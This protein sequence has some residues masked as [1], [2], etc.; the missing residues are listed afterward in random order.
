I[1]RGLDLIHDFPLLKVGRLPSDLMM[2]LRHAVN[3]YL[4][5]TLDSFYRR[6]VFDLG[7]DFL[8]RT[9]SAVRGLPNITPNG[10]V[11][12]K[13]QNY[14]AYNM[15]HSTVAEIFTELGL[16]AHVVSAHAPINLRLVDGRANPRF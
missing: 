15:V 14:L 11:L 1:A 5:V 13:K 7:D 6:E 9:A 16:S 8:T 12:A 10:L 2:R 4:Y 3:L